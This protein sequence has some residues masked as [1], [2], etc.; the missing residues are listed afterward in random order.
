MSETPFNRYK[1]LRSKKVTCSKNGYECRRQKYGSG[2]KF[3]YKIDIHI[4]SYSI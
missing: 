2:H 4:Q 3:E 1:I